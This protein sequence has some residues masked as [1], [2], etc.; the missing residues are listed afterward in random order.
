MITH[1][2]IIMLIISVY[3]F[4]N[5]I[6]FIQILKKNISFYTKIIVVIKSSIFMF[7]LLRRI[8]FITFM[9]LGSSSIVITSLAKLDNMRVRKPKPAPISRT[10]SF[11]VILE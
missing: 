10:M 5:F 11:F 1:L 9:S 2:G 3:E 6:K 8:S 4:L 7:L